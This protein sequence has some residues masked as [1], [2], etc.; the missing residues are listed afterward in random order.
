MY[1]FKAVEKEIL[2][3]WKNNEIYEKVS[4]LN[5]GKKKF[6]FLQGPPYTSGRIHMG[7][8][9]NHALKDMVLRYKR[10]RGLDVWDR[11]GYDMHGLPTAHRVQA[12][13]DLK[14]KDDIRK[15]GLEKFS[16]E[17]MKFATENARQMDKDI[18]QMGVWMDF[19]NAYWPV[20][21]S[22]IEGIWWLIKKAHEKGRLYEGLRTMTWCASCATALAKHECHYHEVT[23]PSI[24]VKFPVK[25][26]KDEYFIIWTTTP[27]TIALNLAIMVNP[28]LDYVRV[29]AGDEKWIMAK[30][31]AGAL[32]QGVFNKPLKI[33]EEFKGEELEGMEYEHP[34]KDDIKQFAE[35]KKKHANV[36]TILLSEEHV[37]LGAGSGLVHCAPGCGPEDYEVGHK[38]D[39]PP[40]NFIDESGVFPEDSGRFSGF[41][42]KADDQKFIDALAADKVLLEVVPV[43]HDYAHCERCKNPVVF[44]ATKQWFFK[45]EDLKEKMLE[46]NRDVDWVPIT[47][48][49]AFNSWLDNLRDNSITK[50]RFWG[51]P[52]PIWRCEE[53]NE[54][55]V[56]ENVE[57][58]K[59]LNAEN[60]PDNLHKPWIDSVQIPCKCGSTMKRIP[61]ILDVW[62][63]AGSASWNCLEYPKNKELFEKYFP[64]DF[65]VEGKDQIRGWFNLLMIASVLAFDKRPFNSVHMHGFVS[66]VDG[67]KMSK[68]LGNVIS[69]YE[70]IDKHGADTMRYY[71]CGTPA[72]EDINFSWDEAAQRHRHL[73]VLWNVHQYLV[74]YAKDEKLNP[75][76]AKLNEE[77]IE[78]RYINSLLHRSMKQVTELYENYN[79]DDVPKALE[80]LFLELSR[81]YIKLTREKIVENPNLV[82]GTI[83]NVLFETLKMQ[84]TL[85]PFISEKIYQNLKKAFDLEKESISLYKWP[86]FDE[87]KIDEKLERQFEVSQNIVQAILAAREK[88]NLG[89]RWP[90]PV[91][92]VVSSMSEVKEAVDGLSDLIK[93]QTNVKS[94]EVKDEIAGASV[95]LSPNKGQIGKDFKQDSKKVLKA[96]DEEKME[97]L[98]QEGSLK[99]EGFDLEMKHINIKEELPENLTASD[100][101]QG[102]VYIETNLT[103]E[104]EQEGYA[105]EVVRRIQILRKEA[106]LSKQDRVEVSIVSD[107]DLEKWADEIKSKVG[108]SELFF[109]EKEFKPYEEKIKGKNFKIGIKI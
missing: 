7:Q 73:V 56:V 1:D 40:F 66:G 23:E 38:N 61:D 108:A 58:L 85:T 92:T 83:F 14:T 12:M 98:R 5:S 63:D 35:L 27:W 3:F 88:A 18:W 44:R 51:T 62:I 99:V 96:L 72:G 33:I 6:Y 11:A 52:L 93:T 91:A 48:K 70:L 10:M 28:K 55:V 30:G 54:Y 29:E 101:N 84:S 32:M 103:P 26:K 21:N 17:C 34:W 42:A 31:L 25:G 94:L 64:A 59:K 39:I 46:E 78:E 20:R 57:E 22:Y 43:E 24:Y 104:L 9:W 81:T 2:D 41:K 45:V 53:C 86:K 80:R 76:N 74:E 19:E 87:G 49:N 71:M 67:V 77:G 75:S 106:G 95:E 97:N 65:I 15:F 60:I 16:Q 47:A 100:F 50:Q 107:V 13:L 89:V 109:G 36:H 79:L 90:L 37:S 8:A 82:L 68:S 105:R 102:N 69:P 4:Q